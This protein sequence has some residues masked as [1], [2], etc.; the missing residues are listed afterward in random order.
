MSLYA[1]DRPVQVL[2]MRGRRG[3]QAGRHKLYNTYCNPRPPHIRFFW[4][5]QIHDASMGNSWR[6]VEIMHKT[7][8]IKGRVEPTGKRA[9]LVEKEEEKTVCYDEPKFPHSWSII[10]RRAITA[11]PPF[12]VHS[13]IRVGPECRCVSAVRQIHAGGLHAVS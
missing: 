7:E 10:N 11:L 1:S 13:P 6:K 9:A 2:M 5:D 12:V 3:A 8:R 4:K